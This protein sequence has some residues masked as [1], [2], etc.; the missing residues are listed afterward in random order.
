MFELVEERQNKIAM[1]E[2]ISVLNIRIS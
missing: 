1:E 2:I